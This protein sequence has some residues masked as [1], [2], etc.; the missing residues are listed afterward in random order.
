MGESWSGD[1]KDVRRMIALTMNP[2]TKSDGTLALTLTLSPRERG[3]LRTIRFD[4][5]GRE[6]E[7]ALG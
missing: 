5:G 3:Q 4:P 1:K 2:N 6:M 7:S